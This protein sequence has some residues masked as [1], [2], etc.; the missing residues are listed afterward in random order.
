MFNSWQEARL[1]VCFE[2]VTRGNYDGFMKSA[3]FA[4]K[5][6]NKAQQKQQKLENKMQQSQKPPLPPST[7][8]KPL[9][10]SNVVTFET[11]KE[12]CLRA[13]L[14]APTFEVEKT[15]HGAVTSGT[16]TITIGEDARLTYTVEGPFVGN[17]RAVEAVVEKAVKG[18]LIEFLT[19]FQ[20]P[21]AGNQPANGTNENQN[22]QNGDQDSARKKRR[23]K[24]NKPTPA[25]A[26]TSTT[27]T[28]GPSNGA[29]S[30]ASWPLPRRPKPPV[31]PTS[32]VVWPRGRDTHGPPT[33][34]SS[35]RGGGPLTGANTTPL[36]PRAAHTTPFPALK[37]SYGPRAPMRPPPSLAPRPPPMH[38]SGR[39]D[40]PLP[41]PLPFGY[42]Q[43]LNNTVERYHGYGGDAYNG[44]HPYADPT[45]YED[46]V[47]LREPVMMPPPPPPPPPARRSPPPR[48]ETYSDYIP[49]PVD[50]KG[51]GKAR[52]HDDPYRLYR[53]MDVEEG[54]V[55]EQAARYGAPIDERRCLRRG[56]LRQ[57]V[58]EGEMGAHQF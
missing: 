7:G 33:E 17:A 4:L 12:E 54:E 46:G 39:P 41:P 45:M 35:S 52:A 15:P 20:G 16:L 25:P 43:Q 44:Y 30:N 55:R 21:G 14:P 26:P 42:G 57:S 27:P 3:G 18:G 36:P 11:I 31:E 49:P 8:Q 28:A 37:D 13:G 6:K 29:S 9:S 2:A 58:E 34:P 23:G 50:V 38:V 5:G 1:A 32:S 24:R 51:K 40:P 56:A 48:W 53:P 47:F 22:D 10:S 19:P